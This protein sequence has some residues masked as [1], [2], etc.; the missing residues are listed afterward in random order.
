M[1]ENQRVDMALY[2]PLLEGLKAELETEKQ[3]NAKARNKK[4]KP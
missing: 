4:A 3:A 1:S 2:I